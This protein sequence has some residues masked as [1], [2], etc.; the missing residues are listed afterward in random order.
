MQLPFIAAPLLLALLGAGSGTPAPAETCSYEPSGVVGIG[1]GEVQTFHPQTG[2][3]SG[4]SVSI[5]PADGTA[6]FS[7]GSGC[8][9]TGVTTGAFGV[10]KVRGCE[11]GSVTVTISSGGTVLQTIDVIVSYL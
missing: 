3:C 6:G 10:F 7:S 8:T 5:S 2:S 11:N 1:I 4:L 9:L